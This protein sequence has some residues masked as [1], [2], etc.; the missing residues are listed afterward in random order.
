MTAEVVMLLGDDCE[1]RILVCRAMRVERRLAE[2]STARKRAAQSHAAGAGRDTTGC[3]VLE[4]RNEAEIHGR[5][6]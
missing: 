1:D 4:G 5:D 2:H 3:A 6:R